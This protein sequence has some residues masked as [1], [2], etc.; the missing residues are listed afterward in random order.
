MQSRRCLHDFTEMRIKFTGKQRDAG[1]A[2]S[3][4]S[5]GLDYLGARYF[6]GA[7][8][9]FTSPD[10]IAISSAHIENPQRWNGYAYALNN[11][12]VNV[13]IGGNFSTDGHFQIT[14]VWAREGRSKSELA[15]RSGNSKGKS[16]GY[17]EG[18]DTVAAN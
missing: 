3:A 17:A 13:D 14:T 6:S 18:P 10:P 9:R 12:L 4:M 8:G 2:G 15:L 7:Q 1:T 11:P 16:H 5:S